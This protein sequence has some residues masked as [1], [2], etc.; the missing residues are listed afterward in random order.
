MVVLFCWEVALL[1]KWLCSEQDSGS[2]S[3]KWWEDIPS[4]RS[5]LEGL[6]N[7][8]AGKLLPLQRPEYHFR[9]LKIFCKCRP[10]LS[11]LCSLA[12]EINGCHNSEKT[13]MLFPSCSI[14]LPWEHNGLFCDLKRLVFL[15]S[16]LRACFPSLPPW[17]CSR[18]QA[19]TTELKLMKNE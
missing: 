11:S 9:G 12:P 5:L 2:L 14:S 4:A 13:G 3:P 6:S 7:Y 1:N 17:N 8:W 10:C 15:P 16:C 18:Y 19:H